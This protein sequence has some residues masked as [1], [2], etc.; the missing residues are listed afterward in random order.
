VL[1]DILGKYIVLYDVLGKCIVLYDVLGKCI[2]LYDILGKWQA[3]T[4]CVTMKALEQK[5]HHIYEVKMYIHN[6]NLIVNIARPS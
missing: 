2:V 5:Q 3:V 1:Y 4:A 6:M